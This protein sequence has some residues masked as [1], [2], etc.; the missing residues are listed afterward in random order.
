MS[1]VLDGDQY[2]AYQ[3]FCSIDLNGY[4]G[5]FLMAI[6][7]PGGLEAQKGSVVASRSP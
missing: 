5:W 6:N 4:A 1:F 7:G 3:R 2:D